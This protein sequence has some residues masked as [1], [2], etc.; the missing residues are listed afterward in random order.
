MAARGFLANW[1]EH[2]KRNCG[3]PVAWDRQSNAEDSAPFQLCVR[4][5]EGLHPKVN[6]A[7]ISRFKTKFA[8]MPVLV[9]L[10]S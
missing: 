8:D 9:D 6:L 3:L 4:S 2:V 5:I 1:R 10:E 7:A